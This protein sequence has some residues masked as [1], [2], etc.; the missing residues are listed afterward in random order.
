MTLRALVGAV[1]G[2]LLC[3]TSAAQAP[4]GEDKKILKHAYRVAETSFDP[5]AISDIYSR[6][7]TPHIFEALYTYDHLARP[8]KIKPL[9]A[10]AMPEVSADFR[11]WTIKVRPGIYY[12]SDPA[13]KGKKREVVAQ[14]FV[15]AAQRIVDPATKSP[16]WSWVET[17]GVVGM[18]EARKAA[19]AAQGPFNYDKPIDGLRALDRYTLQYTLKEPRPRFIE[20][21]ASS[22]LLGAQAREVKR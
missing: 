18:A 22:D 3:A 20:S 16:L 13:F 10:A 5:A 19:T 14:D 2:A 17:W 15:F 6:T 1:I 7:V 11:T 21:I 8:A 12:Q 9:L 4:A